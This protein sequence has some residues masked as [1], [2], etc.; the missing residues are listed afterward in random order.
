MNTKGEDTANL[1]VRVKEVMTTD[2]LTVGVDATLED[3][4]KSME[5]SGCGCVLVEHGGKIVG[6]VTERDIVRRVAAKGLRLRI[7]RVRAIM[8]SP[9]IVIGPDA[10]VEEALRVMANR[11]VRRLPVVAENELEGIVSLVDIASALADKA[12]FLSAFLQAF[13]RQSSERHE[14]WYA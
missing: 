9:L 3:A 11:H 2:P 5:N 12:G 8:S 10:T 13:I 14:P 1:N 6:I 7:T 4:A